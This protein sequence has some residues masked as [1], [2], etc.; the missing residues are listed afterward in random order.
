M[1]YIISEVI[2][3]Y[4]EIVPPIRGLNLLQLKTPTRYNFAYN[5]IPEQFR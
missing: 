4:F 2:Y 5:N 3:T 1:V